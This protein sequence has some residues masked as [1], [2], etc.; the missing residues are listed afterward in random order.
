MAGWEAL[1]PFPFWSPTVKVETTMRL[2]NLPLHLTLPRTALA[3][4]GI[5]VLT[6][7]PGD[8]T[9]QDTDPTDGTT[10]TGPVTTE[11]PDPD[12]TVGTTLEPTTTATGSTTEALDDTGTTTGDDTTGEP[13]PAGTCLGLDAVGAIDTVLSRDGMPIDTTCIPDPTPCGGDPVGTWVLE[14]NCGF[15]SIPNPFEPMCPGSTFMLEILSQSGTMT[16]EDDGTFVQD[17]DIQ[18]QLV[19]SLDTMACFGLACDAFEGLVQMDSP[20]ATCQA[21][22]PTCSCTVPDDGMP[23]IVMGTYEV[24][25]NALMVT[26]DAE[27]GAIDFCIAG[28]RLDMWQP[29]YDTPVPTDTACMDDQDCID[30]LGEEHDAYVCDLGEG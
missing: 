1:P 22:G 15:E 23:E 12:T 9:T 2:P 19:F 29:L 3:T 20:T 16:F 14:D 24:M 13:P 30:A 8:D 7:C 27:M 4:L 17:F 28:D 21:M 6:A 5:L 25:G 11:G 26:I 10:T 18:S